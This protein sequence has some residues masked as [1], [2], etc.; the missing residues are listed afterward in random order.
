MYFLL[1]QREFV[2]VQ[3]RRGFELLFVECEQQVAS[4]SIRSDAKRRQEHMVDLYAQGQA[5]NSHGLG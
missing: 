1:G 2:F 4:S 3:H 5:A